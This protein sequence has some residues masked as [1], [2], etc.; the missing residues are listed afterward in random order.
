[1]KAGEPAVGPLAQAGLRSVAAAALALPFLLYEMRSPSWRNRAARFAAFPGGLAAGGCLAAAFLCLALGLRCTTASHL[2][3]FAYTAPVFAALGLHRL[4]PEE[5]LRLG[6]WAGVAAAF[7]GVVFAFS[8]CLCP[9]GSGQGDAWLGDMLGLAAGLFSGAATVVMRTTR[10]SEAPPASSLFHQL[11]VCGPILLAAAAMTGELDAVSW[12]DL[13][14]KD[15]ANLTF[16]TVA[17]S[18]ASHLAWLGL[19]RRYVATRLAAFSFLTPV[20]GVAAGGL[21]LSEPIGVRFAAGSAV[22]AVGVVAAS[23]R[24]G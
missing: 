9:E 2:T 1:V 7:G 6:Q 21:L 15:W 12:G 8:E 4:V 5:R 3:V 23:L 18:F 14:F 20:F 11:A 16:Q 24:R 22:A 19:L 13:G 17:V 10:L